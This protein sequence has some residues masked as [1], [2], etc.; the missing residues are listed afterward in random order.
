MHSRNIRKSV[1]VLRAK[2][3]SMTFSK[4]Y[5][6]KWFIWL[7]TTVNDLHLTACRT[8][9][10]TIADGTFDILH[11]P[12]FECIGSRMR[13]EEL[14]R[15]QKHVFFIF[16]LFFSSSSHEHLFNASLLLWFT[17]WMDDDCRWSSIRCTWKMAS[18]V[19]QE[20]DRNMHRMWSKMGCSTDTQNISCGRRKNIVLDVPLCRNRFGRI[21]QNSAQ[22]GL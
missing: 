12:F 11:T 6:S 3:D 1:P 7:T 19:L 10:R 17:W 20:R 21:M 18:W 14:N 8:I 22:D 4:D 15:I 5:I 9:Q 2:F 13:Y 16:F